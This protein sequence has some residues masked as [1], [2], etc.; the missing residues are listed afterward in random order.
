MCSGFFIYNS[1]YDIAKKKIRKSIGKTT[2]F[3]FVT[4]IVYLVLEY[5]LW[6]DSTDIIH[7]ICDIVS[8]H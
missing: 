8:I 6:Q 7:K 3:L 1:N 5:L 2:H 4:T